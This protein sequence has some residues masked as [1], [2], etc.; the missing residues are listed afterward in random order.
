MEI[1]GRYKLVDTLGEGSLATVY[2]ALGELA[3]REVALKL[4]KPEICSDPVFVEA[5]LSR[6]RLLGELDHPHIVNVFDAGYEAGSCYLAMAYIAGRTLR[7]RRFE[8]SLSEQLSV[9]KDV[10]QALDFAHRQGCDHGRLTPDNILIRD[11]DHQVIVTDF[12]MGRAPIVTAEQFRYMS[13]EQRQGQEGGHCSDIYSLGVILLLLIGGRMVRA[14]TDAKNAMTDLRIEPA[15]DDQAEMAH[16]SPDWILPEGLSVFQ[17]IVERALAPA[18]GDRYQSGAEL[19]SELSEISELQLERAARAGALALL[20]KKEVSE[21]TKETVAESL[22][23]GERF[24]TALAKTLAPVSKTVE[25]EPQEDPA[26]TSSST[27]NEALSDSN[28]ARDELPEASPE[29]SEIEFQTGVMRV[30]EQDR[31]HNPLQSEPP[32]RWLIALC[33]IAALALVGGVLLVAF[34]D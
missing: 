19:I 30:W 25:P 32:S 15:A 10:A 4:V 24:T 27:D 20:S 1:P 21:T 11:R 14:Q 18:P 9:V 16:E 28:E 8:L 6:A 26:S 17:A 5:F 34:L 3:E 13:P 7:H 2:L 31:I 22:A 12:V 23:S 33:G 29:L